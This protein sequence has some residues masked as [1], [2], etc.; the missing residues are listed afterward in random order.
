M[1]VMKRLRKDHERLLAEM[2]ALEAMLDKMKGEE[3]PGFIAQLWRLVCDLEAHEDY[4][5]RNLL[6]PATG[7]WAGKEAAKDVDLARQQH[8]RIFDALA[9]LH[10]CLNDF[11][12]LPAKRWSEGHREMVRA[13][14]NRAFREL[15]EHIRWENRNLL[16]LAVWEDPPEE[17]ESWRRWS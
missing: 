10:E 8:S 6:L 7:A 17:K 16:P 5:E 4:E 13:L 14:A 9:G 12:A 15:R 1:N 3:L 11:R 2:D